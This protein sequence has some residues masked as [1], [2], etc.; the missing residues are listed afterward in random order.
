MLSDKRSAAGSRPQSPVHEDQNQELATASGAH[1]ED[2]SQLSEILDLELRGRKLDP[3]VTGAQAER[4]PG[5]STRSQSFCSGVR[6]APL[7]TSSAGSP[8]EHS[9]VLSPETPLTSLKTPTPQVIP[10]PQTSQ[11]E[12]RNNIPDNA[13]EPDG[14]TTITE[15]SCWRWLR[16]LLCPCLKI[17]K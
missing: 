17:R 5:S 6:G 16:N 2:I 4:K 3:T 9:T 15:N 8:A 14:E 10:S 12:A 11:S 7:P 1:M 13:G